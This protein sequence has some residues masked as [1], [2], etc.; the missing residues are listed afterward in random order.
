ME[1]IGGHHDRIGVV[2]FNELARV[3]ANVVLGP[4]EW[5][6]ALNNKSQ[7]GPHY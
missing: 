7:I 4:E 6:F 3:R 5:L 1:E 2:I